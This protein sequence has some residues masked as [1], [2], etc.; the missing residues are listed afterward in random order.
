MACGQDPPRDSQGHTASSD[1]G[2]A[3]TSSQSIN[4]DGMMTGDPLTTG[5]HS[6]SGEGSTGDSINGCGPAPAPSPSTCG[7]DNKMD[8]RTEICT[9]RNM[10]DCDGPIGI[11]VDSNDACRWVSTASYARDS[12]DCGALKTGGSCVALRYITDGCILDTAC[13]GEKQGTVYYR[14]SDVCELEIFLGF[15]CGFSVLDWDQCHWTKQ[16]SDMCL[17]PYP[18]EG[19]AV[20]NCA[21]QDQL[22]D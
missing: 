15:F 10:E 17:L 11:D 20:C 8:P 22:P 4:S 5:P 19:P 7:S 9:K 18:D 3:D 2:T 14:T 12:T 21:C 16:A 6:S 1:A 13:A